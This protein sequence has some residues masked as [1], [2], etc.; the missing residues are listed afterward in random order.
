MRVPSIPS[1]KKA[2]WIAPAVALAIP[3]AAYA[4]WPSG[5]T[6]PGS[7]LIDLTKE[8]LQAITGV[9]GVLVPAQTYLGDQHLGS[10]GDWDYFADIT[11]L[12]LGAHIDEA[13]LIP[14]NGVLDFSATVEVWINDPSDVANISGGF[15]EGWPFYSEQTIADCDTHI[16]A[17]VVSI[18]APVSLAI[19]DD[20]VNPPYLDATVGTI[21]WS[22]DLGSGDIHLDCWI[23]DV[24]DLANSIGIDLVGLIINLANS[25]ID[26]MIQG[27]RPQIE[28]AVEDAFGAASLH[29]DVALGNGTMTVDINPDAIEITPDGVRVSAGGSFTST[30][31][32]CVAEY[33]HYESIATPSDQPTIASAPPEIWTPH[34]I[35]AMIDDDFVNS[36]LFA[37]YNGG[38]LCYTLTDGGGLPINT[39]LLSLL[40]SEVYGP[41]FP[42]TKPM[43]VQTRPAE[44]PTA[45]PQGPHD[46]NIDVEDLGVDFMAELDYRN[47]LILG[48]DLDVD[49]GVDLTFDQNTGLLAIGI[50]LDGSN[51]HPSIRSNE[52]APGHDDEIVSAFSGLFDTIVEPLLG[53]LTGGL[54]FGLPSISGVGVTQAQMAASGPSNDW[55]GLYA[56]LGTVTYP[57]SDG[58]GGSGS[59]CQT[60]CGTGGTMNVPTRPFLFAGALAI[61]MMR[62]RRNR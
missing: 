9:I 49:A 2:R 62:R 52:F 43:I 13:H 34:H 57:A 6:M 4:G 5:A 54:S 42:E 8:G 37:A 35:G 33:G 21:S 30:T 44:V 39:T 23:G 16:D 12:W 15:S 25:Q 60:G 40:D 46:V 29:Q 3:L 61:A 38:V 45:T 20:Q 26:G 51:I 36:A 22:T 7:V 56:D 31:N 17:F 11:N 59:G 50:A 58:C 28:A 53:G 55:F 32:E 27:F 14:G 48:A 24:L 47:A 18:A 1:V 41:M 19:V 10:H